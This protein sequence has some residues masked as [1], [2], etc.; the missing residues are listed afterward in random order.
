MF[1]PSIQEGGPA[2]GTRSSRR[3]QRP[4][5]SDTAIQQPKAKRQRLP[6]SDATFVNPDAPPEMYEVKSDNVDLLSL[7]R[8]GIEN[9]GAPRRELS[10]R[11]RKPKAGER[12]SKGD[13]SV[14]LTSNS[15]YSV[16][17]LPALP[18]RIRTDSS[19]RYH[20]AIYSSNGYA[21]ALTLTHAVVW[22]YTSTLASPETFTF[23]LP[24]PSK[25]SA[26]PLPL[27][28]L[29][30]PS[31]SSENPGLVVV[32]PVSGKISYWESI[33][34][35]STL[36]LNKT[37]HGLEETISGM[38]SG[39]HVVQIV[40]AESAGFVLVF[41]S[42]RLAYMH[43]RDGHGRPAISVQFL[44]NAL[45][46]NHSGILSSIRHALSSSPLRG[47]IAAVRA[48]SGTNKIG[49]RMVVAAT[50]KGKL[51][52]WRVHRGG[53]HEL[54][55]DA[56]IREL[57]THEILQ[58]DSGVDMSPESLEVLDFT[59]VPRSLDRKYVEASRL[60][61]ALQRHDDSIQHL[62]LLTSF[63]NKRN[64]RYQLVEV[65]ISADSV[66]VGTV[67]PL[68]TY[69]SPVLS[70]AGF[71]P[72]V[73]LPRPAL[74][75]FVIF[76]RAA[77]IASMVSP[78]DSPDSQLQEDSHI[79]P[80][81][82]EDVIDFRDEG[83][84]QIIGSGVEEPTINGHLQPPRH[85]TKN[86]AALL[87]LQGVGTV[88]VVISDIDRFTSETPPEITAKT[89]LEQAVFY[90][91]RVENPLVFSGRRTLPFSDKEICNAAVQLSNEIVSSKAP[92]LMH[93][94]PA[95][96]EVNMATRHG[97]LNTLIRHLKALNVHL[98][99]RTR[100]LLLYNA[101]KMAVASWIWQKHEEFTSEIP[102]GEKALTSE[103]VVYIN[104]HQK[105]EPNPEIGE[106]DPVRHWFLNDVWRLDIYIAWQ[107]QVIKYMW[108]EMGADSA[109]MNRF[110]WEACTINNGALREAHRYRTEQAHLYG[111][112]AGKVAGG[113]ALPEPWT[114]T[115][116]IGNNLK[117]LVEFCH[118][119]LDS[120][121]VQP[122]VENSLDMDILQRLRDM[123]PSLTRQYFT[124][125]KEFFTWAEQ[126]GDSNVQALGRDYHKVYDNDLYEKILKLKDYGLWDEGIEL[127]Q[128]WH[129]HFSLADLVV[130]EILTLEGKAASATTNSKAEEARALA[131]VK[132]RQMGEFMSKYGQKFAF[133]S[134]QFL[135]ENSGVQAVLDFPYDQNRFSTR[136]LR[137]KPE[138]AKISW[139]N[140]VEK[141]NDIDH[142]AET[143][144][145]LG[146]TRE[147][148]LWNKKIELSLS[149]LALLA[150]EPAPSVNGDNTSNAP[151]EA[152]AKNGAN[153]QKI[154]Q[155]LEII[156]IQDKLYAQIL[157][158]IE[159]AV[160]QAA[161]LQLA[162][163]QHSAFISKKSK[164]LLR[165]F[166][167]A[168][169]RLLKHEALEP[170]SLIDLLTLIALDDSHYDVMG[171][172]FYLALVVAHLS[173]K[174][175]ERVDAE[176]LIW[177]RCYLRTDWKK[178]NETNG[179]RDSDQVAL[180]GETAA[181]RTMFKIYT[182]YYSDRNFHPFVKPLDA[183]GVFTET[184]DRRFSE[185]DEGFRVTLLDA[186]KAEDAKLRAF[187][188]KAQLEAWAQETREC[189]KT[190]VADEIDRRT[191]AKASSTNGL[192]VVRP[193][194]EEAQAN[195]NGNG[196]WLLGGKKAKSF[197]RLPDTERSKLFST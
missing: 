127:A 106:V 108:K 170:L 194:V 61:Q 33:S 191:A 192:E 151:S 196:N 84:L 54:V 103:T 98:D 178:L 89:K 158:T 32:M 38:F 78:P 141:E 125:L 5:S 171:D 137:T 100:W 110:L 66:K 45:N 23:A 12:A 75:A 47:D 189:A 111:V 147:Q 95:S 17:K 4:L 93:S 57:L 16:S 14:I 70:S 169:G 27:G 162:M 22:P 145:N 88:R 31:T 3:R 24:Y 1:S 86:P 168:L 41:S 34:T 102:A 123:L 186:M 155:A 46:A 143:L 15:A 7:K 187:I 142:A 163:D 44:R 39:E 9:V 188:E 129:A 118:S 68:T 83:S 173:L 36:G 138:L 71:K 101:E 122:T 40:D 144:M 177:R 52:S 26:D 126:S 55:T 2:K 165:V 184:L 8:D 185:M 30:A 181:Y 179:K 73:Y 76:D 35:A 167:D 154:D 72:R 133:R 120:Y 56:D 115:H 193:S 51:L 48:S 135:L 42:G 94:Q 128:E 148:R 159:Q 10:V 65:V 113:N 183:L 58:A 157:P 85:R 107:Y 92:H 161:E 67:R 172:Q 91:G 175:E 53:H 124:A 28:S 112:D 62:L 153:L 134:Y 63:S 149:K 80:A 87:L 190:T 82:F 43:V 50:T 11:S 74:V 160:D 81:T 104:E 79:I 18:D 119:W 146:L 166:E 69:N 136:F 180:V 99:D 182:D 176:R 130:Q 114:A 150:E 59:F 64:S 20:G 164:A 197:E 117:R 60:S 109:K 25:N 132:R 174:A 96:V 131:D 140:D 152:E 6:L 29:V 97:Y 121:L 139:I 90:S 37:P 13:G 49:E 77:V 195:G 116:F 19:S 105:T 156:G 21:L